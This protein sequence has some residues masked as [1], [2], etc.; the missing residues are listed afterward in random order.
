MV[1]A[2]LWC[3]GEDVGGGGPW[4][5]LWA[6]ISTGPWMVHSDVI[7][8]IRIVIHQNNIRTRKGGA[9]SH[10]RL[11]SQFLFAIEERALVAV[12]RDFVFGRKH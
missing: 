10:Q 11:G 3:G 8:K 4:L 7:E 6:K 9:S 2:S 12:D 5:C 1:A